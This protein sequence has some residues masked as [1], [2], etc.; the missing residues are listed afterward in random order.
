MEPIVIEIQRNK[1]EIDINGNSIFFKYLVRDA[2]SGEFLN[3]GNSVDELIDW[4]SNQ[5]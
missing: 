1:K 4:L 5:K 3:L 2:R